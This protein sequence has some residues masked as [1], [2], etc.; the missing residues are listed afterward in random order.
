MTARML[1]QSASLSCSFGL[2]G[3]SGQSGLSGLSRLFGLSRVFCLNQTNQ[4][5]QM[6]Q[7]DQTDQRDRTSPRR[8]DPLE[9]LAGHNSFFPQ[10]AK[11]LL[12]EV[13]RLSF[14]ARIEG[15]H[16]DGTAS[17]SK[18]DIWLAVP[19]PILLRPRVALT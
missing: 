11:P 17:A 3:L 18:K 16:S 7:R 2:F 6:N 13:V 19:S 15:A 14:T 5:N 4:I 8:A 9:I 1:K 12:K 10:P